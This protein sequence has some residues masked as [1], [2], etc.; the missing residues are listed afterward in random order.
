MELLLLSCLPRCYSLKLEQFEFQICNVLLSLLHLRSK[1]AALD[2]HALVV[3][4]A[5][6]DVVSQFLHVFVV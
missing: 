3:D 4:S 1:V 2:L 5:F 6:F